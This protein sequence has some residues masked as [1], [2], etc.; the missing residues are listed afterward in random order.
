MDYEVQ[1][2][3]EIERQAIEKQEAERTEQERERAKEKK[4]TRRWIINEI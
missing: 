4:E 2:P 1:R 3:R